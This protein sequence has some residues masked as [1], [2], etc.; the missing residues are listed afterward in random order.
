[1]QKLLELLESTPI[2]NTRKRPNILYDSTKEYTYYEQG[3]AK[4]RRRLRKCM[5]MSF[6]FYR[7]RYTKNPQIKPLKHNTKY[8]TLYHQ[9]QELMHAHDPS[10]GFDSI[11]INK[12]VVTKPHIDRHN[13][14]RSYIL[15]LGDF[16][17]GELVNRKG[18]AR[19]LTNHTSSTHLIGF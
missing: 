9:L 13:R 10:F 4:R 3:R 7:E 19:C 17:G 12:N 15:F 6:G 14:G 16:E 18:E 8:P 2:P 5:S 1:M 11:T